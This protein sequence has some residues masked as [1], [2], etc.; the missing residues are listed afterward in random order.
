MNALLKFLHNADYLAKVFGWVITTVRSGIN[1]FP[2]YV[3]FKEDVKEP[4][5][6]AAEKQ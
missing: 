3:P 2:R 1:N 4:A 5:P 6:A